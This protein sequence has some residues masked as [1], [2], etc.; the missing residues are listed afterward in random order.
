MGRWAWVPGWLEP[1][2]LLPT[3]FGRMDDIDWTELARAD[4]AIDATAHA[5]FRDFVVAGR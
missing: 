2:L 3:R 4:R 5:V 1:Q